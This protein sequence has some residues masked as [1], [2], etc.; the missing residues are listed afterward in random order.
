MS[1]LTVL[2]A[3]GCLQY[4]NACLII[5]LATCKWLL[6]LC[7]FNKFEF[8]W[9]IGRDVQFRASIQLRLHLDCHWHV[10][11]GTNGRFWCALYAE[12]QT[13]YERHSHTFCLQYSC[14][15]FCYF[16]LPFVR[17]VNIRTTLRPQLLAQ[18]W[19][20]FIN[21]NIKFHIFRLINVDFLVIR[22]FYYLG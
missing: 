22:V 10:Y 3:L 15:M 14:Y 20:P 8:R 18:I 9:V 13:W 5:V 17:S 7:C 19:L 16:C 2:T 12:K 1:V 21:N 6:T 4:V 11:L